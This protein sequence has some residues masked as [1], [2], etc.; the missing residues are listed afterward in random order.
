MTPHKQLNRHNPTEGVW[1]DCQRT[2][3]ACLLD[4]HPSEVPHFLDGYSPDDDAEALEHHIA[5]WLA[6]EGLVEMQVAFEGATPLETVLTT[7]GAW[8]PG[9]HWILGGES[10]NGVAHV[11]ICLNDQIVWDTSQNDAGIVGPQPGCGIWIVSM[12]ARKL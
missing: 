3:Y 8:N 1:G 10:A 6:D 2:V 7:M 4:K 5:M 11:V 9:Q 12:L